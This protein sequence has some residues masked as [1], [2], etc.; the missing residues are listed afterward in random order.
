MGLYILIGYGF[1]L[2]IEEELRACEVLELI[3]TGR[4]INAYKCI[5][6]DC[7]G[8]GKSTEMKSA[9]SVRAIKQ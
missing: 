3:G 7:D 2:N 5:G 6:A 4:G 1:L 9:D 8:I